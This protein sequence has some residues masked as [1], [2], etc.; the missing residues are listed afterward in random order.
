MATSP[1]ERSLDA[2]IKDG[3][4]FAVMAGLGDPSY[5]GACALVLGASPSQVALLVTIPVF[6]GA[7][8]QLIPPFF[9]ERGFSRK[10]LFVLGSFAQSLAW[11]PILAAPFA[12]G[13]AGYALLFAGWILYF[14][15]MHFTVPPWT[16]VM[17]DLVPAGARGRFF[18]RRSSLCFVFQTA[19]LV[20]S[21]AGLAL[22]KEAGHEE[23]GFAVVF[24]GALIARLLSTWH[25]SRMHEPPHVFRDED[26]FTFAQF[27]RRLPTSNFAKFV[28]FVGFMNASAHFAGCLFAPYWKKTL[29]YSYW[30][31]MAVATAVVGVQIVALP[32]WGRQAD[33][34]GNKK[35]LAT[36]S[37]GIAV[38]PALW[39]LSAHVGWAVFLQAWSGFFWSGFNQSVANFL[40]D[41]VT[42]PKR[43]RCTAY[44]Y[45]I[46]NTGLLVGGLAGSWA[47]NHVPTSFFG[48]SWP[49]AF[50]TL[51]GISFLARSLT[52]MVF[53]PRFREVRD[54]PSIGHVEWFVQATREV[55]GPALNLLGALTGKENRDR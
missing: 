46:V 21:G 15:A 42:P 13:R 33:R 25:L 27:L 50:W 2:S 44:L 36:T 28:F 20:L 31:Y 51:L 38:L 55:T 43:A 47:I 45:L 54:V 41:A 8:A 5:V 26:R 52:L 29:G 3:T 17:G 1:V 23:L 19:S 12:K 34:Y 9:I 53:L 14:L 4:T 6:L 48:L 24:A 16:S 49:H 7:L 32:F 37:V 30:E 18:G 10:R 39:L 35:V 11:L 40:F 22:Y